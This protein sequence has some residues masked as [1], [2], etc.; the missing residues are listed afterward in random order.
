MH[1]WLILIIGSS[2]MGLLCAI[3]LSHRYSI[4]ISG[5]LPWCTLLTALIY[6][7]YFTPYQ[8][9]GASMWLIAQLFGGTIAA[10]IG[11]G[12]FAATRHIMKSGANRP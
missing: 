7:E 1:I 4:F 12:A 11:V 10:A 5:A 3:F 6:T 2:I 8:G 9:G